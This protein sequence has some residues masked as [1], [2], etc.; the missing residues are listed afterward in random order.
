MSVLVL[1][2]AAVVVLRACGLHERAIFWMMF[3]LVFLAIEGG[4]F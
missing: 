2:I 4:W 3:P 1:I